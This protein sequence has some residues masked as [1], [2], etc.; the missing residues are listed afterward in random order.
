MNEYITE[1]QINR[2]G[3]GGYQ[4]DIEWDDDGEQISEMQTFATLDDLTDSAKFRTALVNATI[5]VVQGAIN[6]ASEYIK[7]DCAK[8]LRSLTEIVKEVY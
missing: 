5:E 7:A 6:Q 3:I 8:A 4:L 2:T 1:I